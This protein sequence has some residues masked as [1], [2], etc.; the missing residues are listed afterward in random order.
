MILCAH[1]IRQAPFGQLAEFVS[2]SLDVRL[3]HRS[4][5][6]RHWKGE[7]LSLIFFYPKKNEYAS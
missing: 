6:A 2:I 4:Y 7:R 5:P 3:M 1:N